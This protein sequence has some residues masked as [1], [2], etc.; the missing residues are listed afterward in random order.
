MSAT[1][2]ERQAYARE[3]VVA[4]AT[5]MI[6]LAELGHRPDQ[7]GRHALYLQTWLGRTNN[8]KETLIYAMDAAHQAASFILNGR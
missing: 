8:P 6:V 7:L 2:R 4:E 1:E 5:A 3:E